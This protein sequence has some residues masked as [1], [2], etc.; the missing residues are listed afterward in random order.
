MNLT[1]LFNIEILRI[2]KAEQKTDETQMK[3][4]ME[5]IAALCGVSVR[6]LYHWRSGRYKLPSDHVP[7]LCQRFGSRALLDEL[8]RA[9]AE[10]EIDV[11]VPDGYGLALMASRAV[12]EDLVVYERFLL[13]FESDGIQPGERDELRL[14]TARVHRNIHQLLAIAEADCERRLA[15][16]APPRKGSVPSEKRQERKADG[17]SLVAARK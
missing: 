11:D 7:T 5:E 15:A 17:G 9:S 3:A 12:R 13:S 4:L 6:T 10:T 16:E 1:P 8:T 14:L 2:A